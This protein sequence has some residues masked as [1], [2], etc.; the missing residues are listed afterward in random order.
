[1][2][3]NF[4]SPLNYPVWQSQLVRLRSNHASGIQKVEFEDFTDDTMFDILGS[5]DLFTKMLSH[6]IK[7]HV[8]SARGK[9]VVIEKSNDK[10]HYNVV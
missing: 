4:T 8:C 7:C 6:A 9:H 5:Q 3:G 2:V 10:T 1:M